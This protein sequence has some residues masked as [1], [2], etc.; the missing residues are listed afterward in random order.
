MSSAILVSSLETL[1]QLVAGWKGFSWAKVYYKDRSCSKLSP[2]YGNPFLPTSCPLGLP[3][4]SRVCMG[5]RLFY[6]NDGGDECNFWG[7][8]RGDRFR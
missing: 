8:R 4:C 1:G 2:G 7:R 3:G 5:E 6:E